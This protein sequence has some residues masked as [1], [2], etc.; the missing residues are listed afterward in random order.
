MRRRSFRQA[1]EEQ[2]Q[3]GLASAYP[4]PGIIER[5]GQ[6]WDWCWIDVQHG[7]WGIDNVLQAVRAC[8]LVGLFSLVRVPGHEG[9]IIG[10]V[11]DMGCDAVMVPMIDTVAQ[12]EAAVRAAKFPPRGKRSYGGRRPIDLYGRAYSHADQPQPLLVCQ[13]ESLEALDNAEAIA[14]VDGVDVLFFGPD[15]MAQSMG[16]P[17]DTPRPSGCFDKEMQRVAN[18]A[19]SAGKIAAGIFATPEALR[20]AIAMGY[21]MIVGTGDVPLLVTGSTAQAKACREALGQKA[22]AT[23]SRPMGMY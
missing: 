8:D 14:A 3:L 15:D 20:G 17:M 13:I 19:T 11:L 1:L 21:R 18:A 5:I 9:G 6:D 2:P 7:E 23:K 16:M 22:G 12:A 4:A 10:R